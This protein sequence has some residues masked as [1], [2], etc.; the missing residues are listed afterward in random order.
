MDENDTVT[1]NPTILEARLVSLNVRQASFKGSR[2]IQYEVTR[3]P[4]WN[5]T[6]PQT[7][8]MEVQE[9]TVS[10]AATTWA[11]AGRPNV[12]KVVL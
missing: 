12:I 9:I 6:E 3:D 2:K 11:D 1:E 4:K 7:A 5:E 8:M 10:I